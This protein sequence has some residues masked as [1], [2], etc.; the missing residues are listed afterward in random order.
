MR[1]LRNPP[2][3]AL[4]ILLSLVRSVTEDQPRVV[5]WP[6]TRAVRRPRAWATADSGGCRGVIL[7]LGKTCGNQC[8][9]AANQLDN[10]AEDEVTVWSLN[11][12][13]SIHL[14]AVSN[15]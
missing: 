6:A 3:K 2:R 7:R 12:W 1:S 5:R 9:I 4:V 13:F 14:S 11:D 10:V 8:G 15:R